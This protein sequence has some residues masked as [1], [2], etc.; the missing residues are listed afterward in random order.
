MPPTGVVRGDPQL[1][2]HV[3]PRRPTDSANSSRRA[4]SPRAL[5][6]RRSS[7]PR[8]A[9]KAKAKAAPTAPPADSSEQAILAAF[10]TGPPD[11][12]VCELE[13]IASENA[14][15][16]AK[17]QRLEAE[18][19]Q[20][21]GVAANQPDGTQSLKL[22]LTKL[23]GE[24]EWYSKELDT[25]RKLGEAAVIQTKNRA[26][27]DVRRAED[28]E[29]RQQDLVRELERE[30]DTLKSREATMASEM[31]KLQLELEHY[32][33]LV[34]GRADVQQ[35][36]EREARGEGVAAAVGVQV[37]PDQVQVDLDISDSASK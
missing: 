8:R 24:V 5:S 1:T 10:G 31:A 18:L 22:E 9:G 33:G 23:H 7:S 35:Q 34:Q 15:L 36:H 25:E 3:D 2:L 14:S 37:G 13:R 21:Q 4:A 32:K 12:E 28:A 26:E 20:A 16:L 11:T 6:S 30:V 27:S 19:A 29:E 17:V